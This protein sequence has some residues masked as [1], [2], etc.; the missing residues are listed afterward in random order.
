MPLFRIQRSGRAVAFVGAIRAD[1]VEDLV[2]STRFR[3]EVL[4]PLGIPSDG[5][6][7]ARATAAEES[8][9]RASAGD[10]IDRTEESEGL[11][12]VFAA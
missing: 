3:D 8:A 5:L 4:D 9:V 6:T 1:E 10:Q 2:A 12:I 11:F 7:V